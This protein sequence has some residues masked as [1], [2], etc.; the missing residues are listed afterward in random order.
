MKQKKL[1]WNLKNN[2]FYQKTFWASPKFSFLKTEINLNCSKI[3]CFAKRCWSTC[4]LKTKQNW[5]SS[6]WILHKTRVN[7][8]FE[9]QTE[10]MIQ[11]LTKNIFSEALAKTYSCLHLLFFYQSLF[12]DFGILIFKIKL[13]RNLLRLSFT[14]FL[15]HM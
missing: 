7:F 9:Y 11:V 8:C 10:P 5:G 2:F 6:I 14:L 4:D 3:W 1:F 15:R 13:Q 12:F